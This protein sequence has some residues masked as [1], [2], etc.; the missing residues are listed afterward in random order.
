M[1]MNLSDIIA[2]SGTGTLPMWLSIHQ[3][4]SRMC[5]EPL[6]GAI[7]RYTEYLLVGDI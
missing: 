6:I 4:R 2:I 7:A 3:G 1:P 5:R